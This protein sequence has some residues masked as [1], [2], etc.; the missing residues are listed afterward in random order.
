MKHTLLLLFGVLSSSLILAQQSAPVT[1]PHKGPAISK[2]SSQTTST[3]TATSEST[4]YDREGKAIKIPAR[5]SSTTTT[6]T[7]SDTTPAKPVR[8]AII[9]IGDVSSQTLSNINAAG[10]LS[11]YAKPYSTYFLKKDKGS[12]GKTIKENGVAKKHKTNKEL[13]TSVFVS[14]NVNASN[15][16]TLVEGTILFPDLG[17]SS[18][19]LTPEIGILAHNPDPNENDGW[20]Y[21]Y[22]LLSEFTNKKIAAT[23]KRSGGDT[24]VYFN[25]N[26]ITVGVKGGVFYQPDNN[27]VLSVMGVFYFNYVHIPDKDST[28]FRYIL[29]QPKLSTSFNSIGCKITFGINDFQIYADVR[30]TFYNPDEVISDRGLASF[31]ANVGVIVPVTILKFPK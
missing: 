3:V 24:S 10:K 31:N 19:L 17:N 4:E 30:H 11:F 13:L 20:S 5:T 22:G 25:V 16:D 15:K 1:I 18:V 6:I 12:D 26:S 7:K 8:F 21:Y 28:D 2:V 14:L 29:R 23:K 9:G 27:T